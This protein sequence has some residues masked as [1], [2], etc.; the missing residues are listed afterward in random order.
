MGGI[1]TL[2]PK[3][4]LYAKSG[5]FPM[6]Q[7]RRRLSSHASARNGVEALDCLRLRALLS[8]VGEGSATRAMVDVPCIGDATSLREL[9]VC[10]NVLVPFVT[11]ASGFVPPAA[12]RFARGEG[13]RGTLSEVVS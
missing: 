12:C 5:Y 9:E 1:P 11:Q 6:R 4:M 7:E 2:N 13:G 8:A 10:A 3:A